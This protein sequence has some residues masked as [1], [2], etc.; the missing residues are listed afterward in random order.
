MQIYEYN[1]KIE[2][3]RYFEK[4]TLGQ[5]VKAY[6]FNIFEKVSKCGN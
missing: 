4:Y 1:K 5:K 2:P 3:I 6:M